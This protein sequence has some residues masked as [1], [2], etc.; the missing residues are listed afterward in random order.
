[1]PDQKDDSTP[2]RR[3]LWAGLTARPSRGQVIVAVLLAVLGF[4]AVVQVRANDTNTAYSGARR[5]DLVQLLDSLGAASSRADKQLTGLRTTLQGLQ[6]SKD[7]NKAALQDARDQAATLALLNGTVPAAG[8]GVRITISDPKN[9]VSAATLLEAVEELRDAGAEAISIND[10]VRVVAQTYF[11][12]AENGVT[13]DGRVLQAPYV[14]E[15]IGSAQTLGSAVDFPGGLGDEV[16]A[17]GG[18]VSIQ[19]STQLD[20]TALAQARQPQYAQPSQ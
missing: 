6:T 10:D 9:A 3:R 13:A 14:I 19:E 7:K 4:A 18:S 2:G 15:A 1:M 12:D 8:P 20:I 16:R 11:S 17:I 5:G